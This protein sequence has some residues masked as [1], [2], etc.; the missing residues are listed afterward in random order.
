MSSSFLISQHLA[1]IEV[2]N[3]ADV[4]IA[5]LRKLIASG[6]LKPGDTLPSERKLA[7]CFGIGRGY[8]RQAIQKLELYGIVETYPQSGSRISSL[9]IKAMEGLF[10]NILKLDNDDFQSLMETRVVLEL[11]AARLVCRRAADQ[12]LEQLR[13]CH[14]EFQDKVACGQ[15]GLEEDMVFHLKIA[16]LCRNSVLKSLITLITPDVLRKSIQADSCKDDRFRAA[17]QEHSAILSAIL[18]R[19]EHA[20]CEAMKT[21]LNNTLAPMKEKRTLV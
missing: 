17:F 6:Q 16:E 2:Q 8:V 10:T 1:P 15:C 19:D 18:A 14:C 13:Q 7:A 11:E 3:P 21:H 4:I 5:Q 12:E 20:V 9:G